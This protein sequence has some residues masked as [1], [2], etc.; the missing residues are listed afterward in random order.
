MIEI[1][2]LKS[3]EEFIDFVEF[4]FTLYRD[5]PYWVPPI[6][7]EELAI[8]DKESN[9][10]FNNADAAFFLAYKNGGIVGR[11]AAMINWIEVNTL[12]KNKPCFVFCMNIL[13]F[14]CIF[15]SIGQMKAF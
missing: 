14:L 9:P 3:K 15:L 10:V 2:E 1:V 12:K 6:K 4:P 5:H 7:K 11:I 13:C 8:M